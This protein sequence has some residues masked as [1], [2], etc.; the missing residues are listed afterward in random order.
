MTQLLSTCSRTIPEFKWCQN[1]NTTLRSWMSIFN[2]SRN[3]RQ[4]IEHSISKACKFFQIH[5]R[6]YFV[7]SD[8]IRNILDAEA[9]I[10]VN[11]Y[12]SIYSF[13]LFGMIIFFLWIDMIRL[14]MI[15]SL[16][17]M[18]FIIENQDENKRNIFDLW[19]YI[20]NNENS[21]LLNWKCNETSLL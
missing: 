10:Y 4:C 18:C 6:W 11:K 20:E 19:N 1:T 17:S 14:L 8:K 9:T 16:E 12:V 2:N 7:F 5:E 13:T 15:S 3:S 21:K